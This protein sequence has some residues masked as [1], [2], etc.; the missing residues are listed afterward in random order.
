[1]GEEEKA[2]STTEDLSSAASNEPVKDKKSDETAV[3]DRASPTKN[4]K[5]ISTALDINNQY[6]YYNC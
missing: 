6:Y 3:N 2:K 4:R 5:V 1:M